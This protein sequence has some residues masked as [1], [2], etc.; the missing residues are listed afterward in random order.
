MSRLMSQSGSLLYTGRFFIRERVRAARSG[1]TYSPLPRPMIERGACAS[2][3]HV[4]RIP[5]H[6]RA[7]C[8]LRV[9]RARFARHST[10]L[11]L[12]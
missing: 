10:I 3:A 11:P 9:T 5:F 4:C 1:F 8:V 12:S 7:A 6:I 2:P